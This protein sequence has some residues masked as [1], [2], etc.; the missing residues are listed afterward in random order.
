MHA[1][2]K[3]PSTGINA[4]P[5]AIARC[6]ARASMPDLA[7]A[8]PAALIVLH[9]DARGRIECGSA[10]HQ[11]AIDVPPPRKFH[12]KTPDTIVALAQD[13]GYWFRIIFDQT[14]EHPDLLRLRGIE[15]KRR[16]SGNG[17]VGWPHGGKMILGWRGT[18]IVDDMHFFESDEAITHNL[19]ELGQKRVDLLFLVD[20]LDQD[21]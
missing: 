4:S 7:H 17:M 5:F 11:K 12:P 9:I 3:K 15:S 8:P 10:V 2:T 13:A 19:V 20:D 14:D 1:A 21:R 16:M 6:P 18:A